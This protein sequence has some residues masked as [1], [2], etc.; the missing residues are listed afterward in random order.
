MFAAGRRNTELGLVL[1]AAVIT[2]ALYVLASLGNNAT[3]P[4][5][6]G[7]FL[8]MVVA[9][10]IAAHVATRRLAPRADPLLLPIAALLNGPTDEMK[11][12]L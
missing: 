5:N 1:F 4:A 10:L 9:L 6:L 12:I 3:I 8:G 7:P 2:G 11:V